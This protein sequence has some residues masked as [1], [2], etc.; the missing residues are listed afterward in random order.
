MANDGIPFKAK[1]ADG[2]PPVAFPIE[3]HQTDLRLRAETYSH[4]PDLYPAG[5]I[6]F[7]LSEYFPAR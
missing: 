3:L 5:Q 6:I 1:Q 4:I 2:V 7:T